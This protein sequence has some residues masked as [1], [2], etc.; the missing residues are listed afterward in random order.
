MGLGEGEDPQ[1]Q[2]KDWSPQVVADAYTVS[3]T[4]FFTLKAR[5]FIDRPKEV[6]RSAFMGGT[7]AR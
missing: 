3:I 4:Q 2:R 5:E 6:P 7:I 1:E